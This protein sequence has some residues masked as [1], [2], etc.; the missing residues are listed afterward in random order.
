L[1]S[2]T[3]YLDLDNYLNENKRRNQSIDQRRINKIR[4]AATTFEP[5]TTREPDANNVTLDLLAEESFNALVRNQHL[6]PESP[7]VDN[8][9]GQI[10]DYEPDL[11]IKRSGTYFV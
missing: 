2:Y 4:K 6:E 5:L 11:T 9:S 8:C 3:N 7:N 1:T 10:S